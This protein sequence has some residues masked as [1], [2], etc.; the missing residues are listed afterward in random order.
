MRSCRPADR[1]EDEV[2][3]EREH[4]GAGDDA[5]GAGGLL[6]AECGQPSGGGWGHVVRAVA[7]CVVSGRRGR[8]VQ[9]NGRRAGHADR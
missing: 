8:L 2:G 4:R 1:G 6:R 3:A 7:L 9:R 5:P